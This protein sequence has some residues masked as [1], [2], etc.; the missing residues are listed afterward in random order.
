MREH[1]TDCGAGSEY[2]LLGC[3]DKSALNLTRPAG[4]HSHWH[5]DRLIPATRAQ[6]RQAA[7]ARPLT[8]ASW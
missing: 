7:P 8:V 2:F 4:L 3:S 6:A 5:R 1:D